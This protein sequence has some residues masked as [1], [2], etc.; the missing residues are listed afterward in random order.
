MPS[1]EPPITSEQF[2]QW[3][4]GNDSVPG[5]KPL[6]GKVHAFND[7]WFE[8]LRDEFDQF[9]NDSDNKGKIIILEN[10]DEALDFSFQNVA[11]PNNTQDLDE[12]IGGLLIE[13]EGYKRLSDRYF[14]DLL[15]LSQTDRTLKKAARDARTNLFN[16]ADEVQRALQNQDQTLSIKASDFDFCT[17]KFLTRLQNLD[18]PPNSKVL[19]HTEELFRN[20]R[21]VLGEPQLRNLIDAWGDVVSDFI[22]DTQDTDNFDSSDPD[23]YEFGEPATIADFICIHDRLDTLY[24]RLTTNVS[25]D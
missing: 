12:A 1:H 3:L 15:T 13:I 11:T 20:R 5:L 14:K 19:V 4:D 10:L 17:D 2:N 25:R 22:K 16:R 21:L 9:E 24:S 7:A 8:H 18:L 6:V 23:I